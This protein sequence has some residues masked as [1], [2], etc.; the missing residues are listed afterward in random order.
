MTKFIIGLLTIWSVSHVTKF[1]GVLSSSANINASVFQGSAVDPPLFV[2]NGYD[3][4]PTFAEN[5]IDKY[6]DDTY[7]IVS[8]NNEGSIPNELLAIEQW[9]T[10]NNLLLNKK[11]SMEMIFYSSEKKKTISPPVSP[12]T[13][14]VRVDSMKVLGVTLQNNLSM[15]AHV[16]EVCHS[17][18]QSLYALKLLKSHGLDTQTIYTV[19]RTTVASRLTYAAP[20]WWGFATADD[21]EK[22]QSV[23][24]R[25]IRW[26]F[27]DKSYPSV[28]E[29]IA[30]RESD[31]FAAVLMN[32][33][34]VLHF[35]LPPVKTHTINLR[36]R[37][38]NRQ[39]PSKTNSH[40]SKNFIHRMLYK[41]I[42]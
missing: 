36:E 10:E 8:S 41:D 42:Y 16:T 14:I 23:I 31:L 35:Y 19:C 40:V 4:K 11:K 26:G 17:A 34:H 3:L 15:K 2:L 30:K 9:A 39:L 13:D 37:R 25:A 22:L 18:A 27:Y 1:R 20:A 24:N 7:L 6:A 28:A 29:I 38:H 5:F 32:K 12:L 21:K 33:Y